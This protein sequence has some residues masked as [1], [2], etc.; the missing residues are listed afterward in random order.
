MAVRHLAAL[1]ILSVGLV[2]AHPSKAED[3]GLA[4]MSCQDWTENVT[5]TG[6]GTPQN[7]YNYA[8][9]TSW[10]EGYVSGVEDYA[11][12]SN[13]V[14][15]TTNTDGN[16]LIGWMDNYCESHPEQEIRDAA[17]QM[18]SDFTKNGTIVFS[19]KP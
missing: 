13:N 18:I 12:I 3:F 11:A 2:N 5:D 8:G 15:V 17:T 6:Q 10:V 4:T 1:T 14:D 7:P 9:M 19:K 16:G